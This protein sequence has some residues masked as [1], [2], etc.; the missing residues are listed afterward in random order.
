MPPNHNLR[1]FMKGISTL[2]RVTGQEH[3]QMCRILLGLVIDIPLSGGLSNVRLIR[4]VRALLDFLYLARYP[5][6]T[7][8]T[9][10]LLDDALARFHSAKEIFVDLGIWDSFNIPK[11]HFAQHYVMFI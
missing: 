3:N 11:L 7:D 10:E 5:V 6:H 1:N 2:S 8:E 4:A 9:L